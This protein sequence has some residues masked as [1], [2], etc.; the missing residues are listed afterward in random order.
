MLLDLSRML[1]QKYSFKF[2]DKYLLHFFC[3]GF[4]EYFIK[5]PLLF[6]NLHVDDLFV[7]N[8]FESVQSSGVILVTVGGHSVQTKYSRTH[9]SF[10]IFA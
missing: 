10:S 9:L 1:S 7:I 6:I 2:I 3:F 5:C 4:H 8:I